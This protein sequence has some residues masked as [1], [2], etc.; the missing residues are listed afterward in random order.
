MAGRTLIYPDPRFE[1]EFGHFS[2]MGQ[3]IREEASR[4]G[5]ELLH[6]V[7]LNVPSERAE[8]EGLLRKLEFNFIYDLGNFHLRLDEILGELSKREAGGSFDI[9]MYTGS[10]WILPTVALLLNKYQRALASPRGH[11]CLFSPDGKFCSGDEGASDY[12]SQLEKVSMLIELVDPGGLLTVCLES[13]RAKR[14]YAPY[15]K[16]ELKVLPL[17][18][19]DYSHEQV[20]A[21]EPD[22]ITIGYIGQAY[23]RSGDELVHRA[24]EAISGKEAFNKVTFKVKH[25]DAGKLDEEYLRLLKGSKNII[26]TEGFLSKE[27]YKE[28]ISDCDIVL[29]P[30]SRSEYVCKTSGIVTE[31]LLREKVVIVPDETWLSD[32]IKDYGSGE[33]FVSD[34]VE[35]FVGA[36]VKVLENFDSYYS[37][38]ARNLD[39]YRALHSPAGLFNAMDIGGAERA[40][41]GGAKETPLLIEEFEPFLIE[42]QNLFHELRVKDEEIEKLRD[43]KLLSELQTKDKEIEKLHDSLSWKVTRPLRR[44][45][46]LISRSKTGRKTD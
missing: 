11:I 39:E 34:D 43:K 13:E 26:F 42:H 40:A 7:S 14:H 4:S 19:T 15:F 8:A 17:P 5:V 41:E 45:S 37:R 31:A 38:R 16:R 32:Q 1:F 2:N 3:M 24:L 10:I 35:S 27:R 21:K 46:E 28:F 33:T 12:I 9:F 30:Y 18:I 6:Y 20:E 25:N 22:G 29:M 36:L 23:R 44:L